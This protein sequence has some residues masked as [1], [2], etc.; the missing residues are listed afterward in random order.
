MSLKFYFKTFNSNFQTIRSQSE[1]PVLQKFGLQRQKRK[2]TYMTKYR[3][4]VLPLL[5]PVMLILFSNP[6]SAAISVTKGTGG[7]SLS[8]DRANNASSPVWT[9]LGNIVITEGN[10][11]D[12]AKNQ[13]GRTFTINA[14]SGWIFNT[15][16]SMTATFQ[17]G[18]DVN[19]LSITATSTTVL[20]VTYTTPNSGGDNGKDILTFGGI[21]VRASDGGNV[22]GTA[23]LSLANGSGTPISGLNGTNCADLSQVVGAM[24]HLLI[25]LPAQTYT[26]ANTAAGSGNSGTVTTQSV[27]FQFLLSLRSVDQFK[28]RVTTYTGS[29]TIAY[30]G[31][32]TGPG[33]NPVYTTSVTFVNGVALDLPTTLKKAETVSITATDGGLYG[34][35]SSALT[36]QEMLINGPYL[37]MA[38]SSGMNIR[39]RTGVSHQAKVWYGPARNNMT[40]SATQNKDT[41]EHEVVLTGLTPNTKY[42][43]KIGTV[44]GDTIESSDNNY[45]YTS[46]VI[47]TEKETRVWILGDCGR[48]TQLQKNTRDKYHAYNG[49][50]YTDLVLLLGDN[51]Y[52]NG[53]DAEYRDK[54]FNYYD[55]LILKQSPLFPCPGNHDYA[56]SN[57]SPTNAYHKLFTVPKAGEIGGVASG[58]Q[59][60]YSFDYSNI[61]FVSLDSYGEV[62]AKK[63]YDTTGA[64]AIWLKQDLAATTQKWKVLY[65]HHPPYTMGSHNSDS[66]S[67][68]VAVRNQFLRMLER[69]DVDVIL[70]GHSHNY[71]RTKLIKGHFGNEASYNSG[72][73]EVSSSSG[74]YVDNS[75]C[76]YVKSSTRHD[77][78]IYV[79][80]GSS[81]LVGS[82]QSAYPHNAMYYSESTHGGT[83]IM[84][85]IGNRLRLKYLN[86]QGNV[87]DSFTL[88]KD[89]N[90]NYNLNVAGT[91]ELSATWPGT[92]NWTGGGSNR[93][94]TVGNTQATYYVNDNQTCL[95]DTFRINYGNEKPLA[96][97]DAKTS[98]QGAA[99]VIDVQSNDSDPNLDAITTSIVRQPSNGSASVLNND[100][101]TYTSN[102]FFIGSDTII[103]RIS[104]GFGLYDTALVVM[105]VTSATAATGPNRTFAGQVFMDKNLDGV[106][107]AGDLFGTG[108]VRVAAF[109]DND[110]N[111][112][113][114]ATDL[115][116]ST[117]TDK[118]GK[119]KLTISTDT[120]PAWVT[121]PIVTSADDGEEWISTGT[122]DNFASTDIEFMVDGT[123][124]QV[125][126]FRFQNVNIGPNDS[127][128]TA[129]IVFTG[130]ASPGDAAALSVRIQ[131]FAHDNTPV[132]TG[133]ASDISG[134]TRTTSSVT[135]T[136]P[137]TAW[138]ANT[139]NAN[140]T[141]PELKNILN[142]IT[143]RSGWGRNNSL[144]FVFT[145]ISGSG[146]RRAF[147]YDGNSSN[148]PK[149]VMKIHRRTSGKNV[150]VKTLTADYAPGTI[151]TSDTMTSTL[152][153]SNLGDTTH[154]NIG[155]LGPRTTCMIIGDG[156]SNET[157]TDELYLANRI[158]GE[159]SFIGYTNTLNIEAVAL[160]KN[161]DTL[162]A[163][164]QDQFGWV[165]MNTGA[166]TA[167][168]SAMGS[169]SG[170]I[171]TTTTSINI[172]DVDGLTYD[173]V[174]NI[175]WATERRSGNDLLFRI[176][177]T[178]GQPLAHAFGTNI[179]Y[180]EIKG[181]RIMD[182]VD[183]IALDPTTNIM[184]AV[185]N[186]NNGDSSRMI[187]I[188]MST[189]I[190]TLIGTNGI[191]DVEGMGYGNDGTMYGT[192]GNT[193]SPGKNAFYTIS[194][195][196]GAASFLG[197][198]NGALDLEGCDCFSGM[199]INF[200]SGRTFYDADADGVYDDG[201]ST[202]RNI[203]VVMFLDKN[204]NGII[205]PTDPRRDS[206]FTTSQGVYAFDIDS[207]GRYLTRPVI[208]ST[209]LQILET[210]TGASLTEEGIFQS[211]GQF[212]T[213]NDFGFTKLAIGD[214]VWRDD[215]KNGVQDAGEPGVAGVVVTLYKN[216][217]DKLPGTSDDKVVASV[218]TD[219]YGNYLFEEIDATNQTNQNTIDSTSYNVGFTLPA[220]YQFTTANSPG[221]N[222]TN[223]NSD[224]NVYTGR[225]GSYNISAGERDLTVDAG[226]VYATSGSPSI[227]DK[228]WLDLNA[229]GT[230]DPGEQGVAG[231]TVSL[232]NSTG[233]TLI[234]TAITDVYGNYRF[235]GVTPG[236]YTVGFSLPPGTEFTT[237]TGGVSA[238]HNSDAI[239]IAGATFGRTS[240][241]TVNAGDD[242]TYVDAGIKVQATSLAILGDYV[243][244]DNDRDG[245]QDSD[246]PGIAGVTVNLKNSGGTVISTVK[247]DAYGYFMFNGLSAGNYSLN[248]ETPSGLTITQ[249]NLGSLGYLDS[250]A[251]PANGNTVLVALVA[252]EKNTTLD[253]GMHSTSGSGTV[254]ALGN[255]VWHDQD[256]DGTQDAGEPG[257]AG[258][259]VVLYNNSNVAIDTTSTDINGFYLF[260][261]LTP[262]NYSVGFSNLPLGYMFTAKDSG[263]N[264]LTDSDADLN[265]GR[266]SAVAVSGGATN[267]T[268][269]A[270]IVTGAPAGMGSIG[271]KVW[272][273]L[274][275][276][277]GG[278]NG[279]GIQDAGEGGVAGVV[280]ELLDG[281]GNSID[282]DGAGSLTKTETL[283]NALGEYMFSG[284]NAGSYIVQFSNIPSG[285]SLTTAN[286]G[287]D[288]LADSDGGALGSGG[289]PS[290]ASRTGV[291]N[292]M[293]GEDNLSVDLG[294]K[295]P[296]GTN[297]L[298]NYVWFDQD[299]DG[300]QDGSERGVPGV[301]VS[302]F[303]STG[304]FIKSTTTDNN[305]LYLFAGV[306]DGT[307][308]VEFSNIPQGMAFTTQ[309][310]SN[311][312]TGSDAN[313]LYGNS[314]QVTL[315]SS[316]RNDAS[317]DA[318]L[319]SLRTALG[320]FVWNDTDKDGLQDSGEP[321]ISGVTVS[322][323]DASG[324]SVLASTVTDQ[325]GAYYFPNL[326]SGNYLVGYTTIPGMIFTLKDA[327]S[328]NLGTDSDP[329]PLTGR[330]ASVFLSYSGVNLNQDAGLYISTIA[331]IGDRVWSDRNSNGTQDAGENGIAGVLVTLYNSNNAAVSSAITDGNG[332][333]L[334]KDVPAGSGYYL[335]FTSNFTNFNTSGTP[336][337]NP[338][339]T[340]QNV[341]TGGSESLSSGTESNTD[342]DVTGSGANANKS[343]SFDIA[344]G[345]IF[346]N[347]DAGIVNASN[348]VPLPVTWLKFNAVLTNAN[349]DALL[350][351]STATEIN[352][353][354]FEVE[355]SLDAQ[356]FTQIGI[357]K[358][359]SVS[360]HSSNILNYDFT[361]YMVSKLS[362]NIIYYRVKQ[363]DY[364]GKFEYTPIR[365]IRLKEVNTLNVYPSP[366]REDLTISFNAEYFSDKVS[367]RVTDMAGRKVI[368]E[369]CTLDP[370]TSFSKTLNIRHLDAGYYNLTISD[371]I[372][373]KQIR[374]LKN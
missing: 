170:V 135:W 5:V 15:S 218:I 56:N 364:D 76:A 113:V 331:N 280:V 288:D 169:I 51:A 199:N 337:G 347:M 153:T 99:K 81:A 293:K 367:I 18:Q 213:E 243:W 27:N 238:V 44:A 62:S 86:R 279:N 326:T 268:L 234:S 316:N 152:R 263:G 356:H 189:G 114:A 143:N 10:N 303:N 83:A 20:T 195:S 88:F 333:W 330:S 65:W 34:L 13:S 74:R 45:F 339:W 296:S 59:S 284:L 89:V 109:D 106:R 318:G 311:D 55:T 58:Q 172:S 222:G 155:M 138:V 266:T 246:E 290:G 164:N 336:N 221:D 325:N 116:K 251:D 177:R 68:L 216:G 134:R 73:H 117:L 85:V 232:Y 16:A 188:N 93:I 97:N 151:F 131:G 355:R 191:N 301:T 104:D 50:K 187:T 196:N 8:A 132:F 295:P 368:E 67:D 103:Y 253:C 35:A 267:A 245:I 38:K 264:D 141:T 314:P 166:F 119:Y 345:N 137:T 22:P 270:G 304:V 192:S 197:D 186:M 242:I 145:Q 208:G 323:Y 142:E 372:Q 276:T 233:T 278:T 363:V 6:L 80:A 257:A 220:N 265:T 193:S 258:I 317:L 289:A 23:N 341:G 149:L 3:G 291:I 120:L 118:D 48:A 340:T 158:T 127:V 328:E 157:S 223:N 154:F 101:I 319:T 271:N 36:V 140:S 370:V 334:M 327:S 261:N 354:H 54:F 219:A 4:I 309:S 248:F 275:A 98:K 274:P 207:Q 180:K 299:Q 329:D 52:D 69:F 320:N 365:V 198:M 105:T 225:T 224:V 78:T 122:V 313:V 41:I 366:A 217:V 322:L 95:R 306:A 237:N 285:H 236:D 175:L 129:K 272:Y 307:Y 66:E 269:D 310:V 361:D 128:I 159:S 2:G 205:D 249:K 183:D 162:Y 160:M 204:N 281:S 9:T 37:Q 53:T 256:A 77:G 49:N 346:L 332:D 206:M 26:D 125:P 12:I 362:S 343:G 292:L 126:G 202:F 156:P 72:T 14:P 24:T 179:G 7:T 46:P 71:E 31:P 147:T 28:N 255:Y 283:T 115:L 79:V 305:G 231:V 84:D 214:K 171:G 250:D 298:G 102:S 133:G 349:K 63:M 168:G 200:I 369:E 96:V 308:S 61:H 294:I 33:G 194:K 1:S 227:G 94:K 64:Q 190:G 25:T 29:K 286:A 324:L 11:G 357:V 358:S 259:R 360:G 273:D 184:Y 40:G 352:N 215:N 182:D 185:N 124:N 244:Y 229:N 111:G 315:G 91:I 338:A 260:P 75:S 70:T 82:T 335:Q 39:W 181:T 110:S 371:G 32:G 262:G 209:P 144:G 374:F 90:K 240:S 21:Q 252:G 287:S 351:W 92:Y 139:A 321:G 277:P 254:G 173:A 167:I 107:N 100:S 344:A 300:V 212:D 108:N 42:Y 312:A 17:S 350:T 359:K 247:T 130:Q 348:L 241:F 123:Q 342:S 161:M 353:S 30:S 57:T 203:K 112:V 302:L 282:P 373:S 174:S 176:S 178:T 297:T 235:T 201:D 228:V 150:V 226:L 60:Y 43:Y 121:I 211:I 148:A 165:N 163:V 146:L 239:T 47:G 19:A 210:T 87:T 230:Q 136:L